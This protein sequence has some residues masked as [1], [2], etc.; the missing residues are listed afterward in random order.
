MKPGRRTP[1]LP[2][3][4]RL[5]TRFLLSFEGTEATGPP[6]HGRLQDLGADGSLCIDAPAHYQPRRGTLVTLHSLDTAKCHFAS[7]VI[8]YNR[9]QGRLP[10][11]LVKPPRPIE[12]QAPPRPPARSAFRIAAC[13]RAEATWLEEEKKAAAP[14]VLANLSGGGAQLFLWRRPAASQLA[15]EMALPQEFVE[16]AA[17]RHLTRN[18]PTLTSTALFRELFRNTCERIRHSF[19]AV[20]T[21]IVHVETRQTPQGPVY[22]ISLAF[23]APH[24][25]CFRLVSYLERQ[26]IRKGVTRDF[27]AA[28]TPGLAKVA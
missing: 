12:A 9:L 16:A 6:Y 26:A 14:G 23:T 11:L 10:V 27:G 17:R 5:G 4:L 8:G 21:H 25:G 28:A 18:G 20:N 3:P 15:L 24:E 19:A 13:L 2:D 22:G 1:D 7:E